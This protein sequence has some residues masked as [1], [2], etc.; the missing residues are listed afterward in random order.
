LP[1]EGDG[2]MEKCGNTACEGYGDGYKQNCR[3]EEKDAEQCCAFMYIT[4]KKEPVAKLQCSDGLCVELKNLARIVKDYV[5]ATEC[6]CP[7]P[8]KNGLKEYECWRCVFKY[9]LACL[10]NEK[11]NT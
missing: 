3:V 7:K 1:L 6:T 4:A 9:N 2:R 10:D 5:G 11:D 8:Y